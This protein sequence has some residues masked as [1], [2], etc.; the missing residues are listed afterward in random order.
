MHLSQQYLSESM[1]DGKV[2]TYRQLSRDLRV[3]GNAAR[4]MLQD[5]KRAA[6]IPTHATYLIFGIQGAHTHHEHDDDDVTMASSLF[7]NHSAQ[8]VEAKPDMVPEL[9]VVACSESN[10]EGS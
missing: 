5:F 4:A 2:V 7:A 8:D 3:H 6:D 1:L 10:V 9:T